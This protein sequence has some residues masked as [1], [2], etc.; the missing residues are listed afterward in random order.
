MLVSKWIVLMLTSK[1]EGRKTLQ[2]FEL[3]L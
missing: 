2:G 1:Q 3:E